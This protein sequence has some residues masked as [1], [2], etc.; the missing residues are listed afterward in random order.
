M[1]ISDVHSPMCR[2]ITDKGRAG[3]TREEL[4]CAIKA[5]V[6]ACKHNYESDDI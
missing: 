4:C 2:P 3:F 6:S 1:M 5:M